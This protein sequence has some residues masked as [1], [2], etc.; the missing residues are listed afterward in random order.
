MITEVEL[1]KISNGYLIEYV[2]ETPE[3][4]AEETII[5]FLTRDAAIEYIAFLEI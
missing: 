1:V 4:D 5:Y 2:D 3:M